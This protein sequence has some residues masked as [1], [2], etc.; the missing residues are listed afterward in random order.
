[1]AIVGCKNAFELY[2]RGGAQLARDFSLLTIAYRTL[3][4][5]QIAPR[6]CTALR[7]SLA[8]RV[9]VLYTYL[10]SIEASLFPLHFH[11]L[12]FTF[13]RSSPTTFS[14]RP[15]LSCLLKQLQ[16]SITLYAHL[17][18]Y[19]TRY[20]ALC[21]QLRCRYGRNLANHNTRH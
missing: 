14:F 5:G 15:L 13:H 9:L 11:S 4:A 7:S 6:R 19:I 10:F 3:S 18:C 12:F 17:T 8:Y 21:E 2:L 20:P 16:P 1:M